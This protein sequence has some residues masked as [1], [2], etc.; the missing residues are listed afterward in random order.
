MI[1]RP[2]RSTLFPYTTLFRSIAE[3]GRPELLVH[4]DARLVSG[5]A[6]RHGGR[7]AIVD[8]PF[9]GSDLS[10]LLGGQPPLP[11]EH[12]RLERAAVVEGQ[13]IEG[14]VEAEGQHGLTFSFRTRRIRPFVEL[15]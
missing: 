4:E 7:E 5:H 10:R 14:V 8:H 2:P 13:H 12:P 9:G 6:G 1:R 15:S 11:A 3:D